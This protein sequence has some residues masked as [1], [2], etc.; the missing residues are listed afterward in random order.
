MRL[1]PKANRN[2]FFGQSLFIF[3]I[4]FFPVLASVLVTIYYARNLDVSLNGRY[5]N[6]WAQLPL[7]TAIACAGV[8]LFIP[9]YTPAIIVGLYKRIQKKYFGLYALWVTATAFLFAAMQLHSGVAGFFTSFFFLVVYTLSVILESFLIVCHSFRFV[10]MTNIVYSIFFLFLHWYVLN[11]DLA[12]EYLFVALLLISILRLLFYI[13]SSRNNIRN[14]AKAQT[15]EI[16]VEQ[17][18]SLWQHMMFYDISQLT[19]K[20]IDKIFISLFL[21]A[22]LSAIYYNGAS[23]VPFL[24]LILSAVGSAALINLAI[25]KGDDGY[26]IHLMQHSARILSAIVF[27]LFF[28]LLFFRYE[29]FEV[30]FAGKYQS[31]VPIFLATIFVV[32]LRA[33]NFTAVLQNKHKGRVINTGS[34]VDLLIA[35]GL[36][37][38]FSLLMGLPGVALAFTVSTYLQAAYYLYHTAKTVNVPVRRLLP[39]RNW[40]IKLIVFFLLFIA[41]RYLLCL[42]FNSENVLILAC[43]LTAVVALASLRI[44]LRQQSSY[45]NASQAKI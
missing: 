43:I 21:S 22:S 42:Y 20:W 45:G 25:N 34:V 14:I 30:V 8:H 12:L 39:Y 9:T 16:A 24:P 35:C 37:Y 2:S 36:I 29:I 6:F 33:Y 31:S 5:I 17:S 27:P 41:F 38:P 1:L 3:L 18:R 40:T 23:D 26:I 10:A 13:Y 7:L 15:A 44:E 11:N 4:R 32:P 28:F 19:F